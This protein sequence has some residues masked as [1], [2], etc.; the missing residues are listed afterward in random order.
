[1]KKSS[2]TS[3]AAAEASFDFETAMQRLADIVTQLEQGRIPL[4]E[5]V[6]IFEE[7][8]ELYRR[9]SKRLQEVEKK[10]ERLVKTEEG[11][12]LE[13]IEEAEEE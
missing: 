8:M 2:K 10:I 4:D 12:Q 9:C 13:L 7:G 1:M 6:K 5:S 11:F 3:A